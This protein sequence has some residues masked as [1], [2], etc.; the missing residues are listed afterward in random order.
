VLEVGTFTGHA[1]VGMAAELPET[2]QVVTIDNFSADDRARTIAREAFAHSPYG[3]KIRLIEG[4][5][6]ATLSSV[7]G[8]FDIVFVD[9]DK[10]NYIAYYECILQRGLLRPDGLLV[11]D[12]TLWGGTVLD[13][14]DSVPS[15]DDAT[16]DE[17][18]SRMIAGWSQHVAMFNEHVLRDPRVTSVLLTVRDGMTMITHARPETSEGAMSQHEEAAIY[19]Q[20]H[21]AL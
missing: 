10:P 7:E 21:N 12:N 8:D 2:G 4:D 5:A 9:A 14:P 13:P 3:H 20:P 16:G 11:F 17:W 15:L 19:A 6:F 18:M 1:T